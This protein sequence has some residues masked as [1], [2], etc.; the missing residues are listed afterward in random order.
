MKTALAALVIM[1]ASL[2]SAQTITAKVL[3]V[4]ELYWDDNGTGHEQTEGKL[5]PGHFFDGYLV[6]LQIGNAPT[7]TAACE[8]DRWLDAAGTSWITYVYGELGEHKAQHMLSCV[9]GFHAGQMLTMEVVG[10][11]LFPVKWEGV[12][13]SYTP[14]QDKERLVGYKVISE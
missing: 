12:T 9:S 2:A 10:G 5:P 14:A 3:T 1:L 11:R 4:T 13:G 6:T 8:V 7:V